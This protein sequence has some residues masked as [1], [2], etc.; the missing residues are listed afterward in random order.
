MVG[1]N[2]PAPPLERRRVVVRRQQLKRLEN[3][4]HRD[5]GRL[6]MKLK[7]GWKAAERKIEPS[8][9]LEQAETILK[10]AGFIEHIANPEHAVFKRA[11]TQA[12]LKGEKFSLEVALAKTETGLFLQARYDTFVLFDTG[13]LEKFADD[14][15]AKFKA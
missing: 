10:E 12:A 3:C 4:A 6:T 15:S 14:L 13:D 9:P 5:D 2:Q 7:L 11:G 1:L 8:I